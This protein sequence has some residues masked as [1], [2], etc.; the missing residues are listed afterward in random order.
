MISTG[1]IV[2]VLV[3]GAIGFILFLIG[4]SFNEPVSTAIGITLAIFFALMSIVGIGNNRDVKRDSSYLIDKREQ[5]ISYIQ[6][7]TLLENQQTLSITINDYNIKL[8]DYKNNIIR[9]PNREYPYK[10]EILN[11]TPLSLDMKGE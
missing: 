8:L 4:C 10:E 1:S 9:N 5:I 2:L 6:N 11:L 3:F 7:P